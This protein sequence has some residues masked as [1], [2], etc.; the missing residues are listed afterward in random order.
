MSEALELLHDFGAEQ[1][2]TEQERWLQAVDSPSLTRLALL[3]HLPNFV[4]QEVLSG[5][6]RRVPSRTQ[7][8]A[9]LFSDIRDY[10]TLSEGLSAEEVFRLLTEWLT[11][12][13]RVVQRHNGV[14]DKFI[15]DAIMAVFG[16]PD[17]RDAAAAD[18][19]RA[20]LDLREEL[21]AFNLRQKLLKRRVLRIGVGIDAGKV[22]AGF[23]GSHRRQSYTVIGDP[24]NAASCL[25]GATKDRQCDILISSG[26]HARQKKY[27]AAETVYAGQIVVKGR[28]EPVETFRVIGRRHCVK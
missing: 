27:Q 11:E 2:I 23:V 6:L 18:A 8:V 3:Q 1:A 16:V 25:E 15:G 19:V 12:A 5:G 7:E 13:T 28:K 14:V 22:E 24:V 21:A 10:S 9:I 26:V 17:E 20:A 4:V